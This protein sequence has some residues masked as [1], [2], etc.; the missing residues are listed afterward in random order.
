MSEKWCVYMEFKNYIGKTILG[1]LFYHYNDSFEESYGNKCYVYPRILVTGEKYQII[2]PNDFPQSGRILVR[3]QGGESAEEVYKRFGS[4]VSIRINAE[5]YPNYNSNNVYS[6]K[7]SYQHGRTSSEIWIERFDGKGFYQVVDTDSE[8]T[9]IRKE[10]SLKKPDFELS[11]NFVMLRHGSKLYGPFEYEIKEEEMNLF[12]ARSNQ[13]FVGEYDAIAYNDELCVVTDQNGK[14]AVLLLPKATVSAP[15]ECTNYYDWIRDETLIDGFMEALRSGNEYTKDQIRQIKDSAK[16]FLE[17]Y[18]NVQFTDQ[19]VERVQQLLQDMVVEEEQLRAM[20]QYALS[21]SEMKQKLVEELVQNYFE[22]IKDKIPEYAVVRNHIDELKR[23]ETVIE[24]RLKEKIDWET[25]HKDTIGEHE[26]EEILSLMGKNEELQKENKELLEIVNAV[27]DIDALRSEHAH[28]VAKRDTARENYN[29]QLLDNKKLEEQFD[30]TIDNFQD[31]AKQTARVLDSKLLDRILRSVGEEPEENTAVT[32]NVELLHEPMSAKDI[33]ER[34][35]YFIKEKA[36]RDVTEND[37]ANYLICI[38]QGFITTFAGEPGTGKTSLCN[39]LAKSL[40]LTREDDQRRFVDISV[41][42]G[43]TSHKDFIGYYNPLTKKLEKSNAEVYRAF[44][45]MNDESIRGTDDIPSTPSEIAPFIILLDE[46]NLSPIEHYWAAFLRNCDLTSSSNRVI[47]LG[48]NKIW[49][50]P[51]HLRFL[52]TVNFDHT[53]EELSPRFLDRSWIITLEPSRIDDETDED[54]SNAEDMISFQSLQDA[55][56]YKHEDIIDE[57]IQN[58]WEKI[59]AIFR[60]ESL[61]I[62]PRNLK[63]VKRYCAIA[64]K[65]MDCDTPSTKFAPL[66]YAFSQ[67]VLPTINGT[68]ENYRCLIDELLKECSEQAMPLSNRHL[69]RI[70]RVA[71]NNMGFYQFFAR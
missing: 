12:A 61:P 46:A 71:E 69:K 52:A 65:C 43:W 24:E 39:I 36:H 51:D 56:S 40:G 35:S 10:R 6:M 45:R 44:S 63:M 19:R 41:E 42:R 14:E 32:F 8:I 1:W 20:V 68:G 26:Q 48:G 5:P 30:K 47:S 3:I 59:Q 64:C 60:N 31:R 34:V 16:Q 38:S 67:K 62:M 21:D 33:V 11:A 49:H 54:L 58:K 25:E 22:Q 7:Y 18:S 29:Q 2:N 70:K 9:T 27:K 66:D 4:L 23:E 55:F 57:G 37:V 13:Y 50:L 17:N 53:T 15:L 28:W